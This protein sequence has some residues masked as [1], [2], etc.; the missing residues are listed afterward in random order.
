MSFAE[1]AAPVFGGAIVLFLMLV[2]AVA[3]LAV[4]YRRE[5]LQL[6][7]RNAQLSA[8]ND[9]WHEDFSA[10]AGELTALRKFVPVQKRVID[11]SRAEV[12]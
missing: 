8:E 2:L 4:R 11:I 5:C 9:R 3:L 10:Q 12:P 6:R 7:A 1:V